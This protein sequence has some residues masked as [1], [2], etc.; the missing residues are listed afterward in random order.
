MRKVVVILLLFLFGVGLAGCADPGELNNALETYCE[1]N[2]DSTVCTNPDATRDTI[3]ANMFNTIMVEFIDGTNDAFCHDYFAHDGLIDDCEN[4]RFS[5]LPDDVGDLS[6]D[7]EVIAGD[8]ASDFIVKTKYSDDSHAY[9]FNISVIEINGIIKFTAF[10]FSSGSGS[11]P[12]DDTTD[13]GIEELD[14]MFFFRDLILYYNESTFSC[15]DFFIKDALT[16][17][18]NDIDN[19]LG[20]LSNGY[21]TS[22]SSISTN[23][24]LYTAKSYDEL[25]ETA[26]TV[27]FEKDGEDLVASE[28]S[29]VT[30]SNYNTLAKATELINMFV[31]D[32]N[33]YSYSMYGACDNIFAGAIVD[34]CYEA[35]ET[36]KANTITVGTITEES[37]GKYHATFTFDDSDQY[38]VEI[39]VWVI[40]SIAGYHLDGAISFDSSNEIIT[41]LTLDNTKAFLLDMYQDYHEDNM[42]SCDDYFS[43]TFTDDCM[44]LNMFGPHRVDDFSQWY[45]SY[46]HYVAVPLYQS[47]P[48]DDNSYYQ[49]F[50]SIDVLFVLENGEIKIDTLHV[51]DPMTDTEFTQ[52]AADFMADVL[53]DS[54]SDLT[55]CSG[56]ND[57]TQICN[58]NRADFINGTTSFSVTPYIDQTTQEFNIYYFDITIDGETNRYNINYYSEYGEDE[59]ILTALWLETIEEPEDVTEVV[60]TFA[61]DLLTTDVS[62]EVYCGLVDLGDNCEAIREE[63]I[64]NNA[65]VTSI[66]EV[67]VNG[68]T[69]QEVV[70]T[71]TD[72]D[73][74]LVEISLQLTLETDNDGNLVVTGGEQVEDTCDCV[75]PECPDTTCDNMITNEVL[76]EEFFHMFFR[77]Y[78]DET[79]TDSDFA[80]K[81][82]IGLSSTMITERSQ[83]LMSGGVTNIEITTQYDIDNQ[84]ESVTIE[85]QVIVGGNVYIDTNVLDVYIESQTTFRFEETSYTRADGVNDIDAANIFEQY[86]INYL[87]TMMSDITF[88]MTYFGVI[89]S[90]HVQGRFEFLLSNGTVE[91]IEVRIVDGVYYGVYKETLNGVE[92][93]YAQQFTPYRDDYNNILLAFGEKVIDEPVI[94]NATENE[95]NDIILY[96][97]DELQDSSISDQEICDKYF[98]DTPECISR[99]IWLYNQIFVN[100]IT[101]HDD[102]NPTWTI[103]LQVVSALSIREI[104]WEIGLQTVS[105]G[106]YV[107]EE[108][109]KDISYNMEYGIYNILDIDEDETAA[110]IYEYHNAYF[111]TSMTSEDFCLAYGYPLEWNTLYN[112]DL[113]KVCMDNRDAIIATG[114]NTAIQSIVFK[115]ISY[116]YYEKANKAYNFVATVIGKISD[117]DPT[118]YVYQMFYTLVVSEDGTSFIMFTDAMHPYNGNE[119]TVEEFY[120]STVLPIMNQYIDYTIPSTTYCDTVGY[121]D[122]DQLKCTVDR[123]Y[124]MNYPVLGSELILY[125]S[126]LNSYYTG[127]STQPNA[128]GGMIVVRMDKGNGL[129]EAVIQKIFVYEYSGELRTK[130][131]YIYLSSDYM[132]TEKEYEDY[133]TQF[134]DDYLN[135]T[136]TNSEITSMYGLNLNRDLDLA[137]ISNF[138]LLDVYVDRFSE[139]ESA[140][141]IA[142]TFDYNNEEAFRVV[143]IDMKGKETTYLSVENVSYISYAYGME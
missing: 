34:D 66:T 57:F 6:D 11:N 15:A 42:I 94:S 89:D 76:L 96:F 62:N 137:N 67:E 95:A 86:M 1:N 90:P 87:N 16:D 8:N 102:T 50:P 60:N 79:I 130:I 143:R 121:Y 65:A 61:T 131:D 56:L 92:T 33:G 115:N 128:M 91:F 98:E 9:D 4:D 22:V 104:S 40:P 107:V 101:Y 32:Y 109:S 129:E 135:P 114:M 112:Q 55:V 113:T 18:T 83:V 132:Y 31:S 41:E 51:L 120:T 39:T 99:D 24:F 49:V 45:Y 43:S 71:Y 26:Y 136:I 10:S 123:N 23:K 81:Y 85:Y 119:K 69:K 111:D 103:D 59:Y 30:I 2:P 73:D 17:C 25:S 70:F 36:V 38:Q 105:D 14:V 29:Y 52:F 133:I 122:Q 63:L 106:S 138:V 7:I 3:V 46:D 80:L 74:N 68:E 141:Y 44:S 124:A 93:V 142:F 134:L 35:F 75:C 64:S 13:L 27:L 97:I 53:D 48:L 127:M 37:S 108:I 117:T 58:T 88:S 54:L 78:N 110:S 140:Y 12:D 82:N 5:L 28:I 72:Q 84:Y 100:N 116:P 20:P 77:E 126:T 21:H 47:D 19:V 125:T 139:Y 118:E